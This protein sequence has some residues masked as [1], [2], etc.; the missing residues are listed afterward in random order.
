MLD[1]H[2][3]LSPYG[4]R[5][6][7]RY[8][9]KHPFIYNIAGQEYRVEYQPAESDSGMF[10]GNSNWRGPIWMPVN[11]LIIRALLNFYVY[12]GDDFRVECPTGSGKL[13]TLYEVA[14][15]ITGRLASIFLRDNEGQR[16]VFGG[17]K[18]NS[19]TTRTG[20]IVSSFTSIFTAITAR[21]SGQA[22]R[23]AGQVRLQASCTC[24]PPSQRKT[25][26][27]VVDVRYMKEEKSG[28]ALLLL[29]LH[30][31]KRSC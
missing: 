14:E 16:P 3:F 22:I 26:S 20:R 17:A 5:S 2:E 19:R 11:A 18:K 10:G 23:P 28:P 4:I 31:I 21:D 8:H 15:D 9:E 30:R 7:S 25:C 1:E 12:Y 13:K 29:K 6:L 27:P 24:L